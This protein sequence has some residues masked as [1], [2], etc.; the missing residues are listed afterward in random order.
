MRRGTR[1]LGRFDGIAALI[2]PTQPK[3]VGGDVDGDQAD[4]VEHT[5]WFAGATIAASLGA[6]GAARSAATRVPFA[7]AWG[8]DG[9]LLDCGE[10]C[11]LVARPLRGTIDLPADFPSGAWSVWFSVALPD[12][13]VIDAPAASL[14]IPERPAIRLVRTADPRVAALEVRA[15]Y[16][17]RISGSLPFRI[18]LEA[19]RKGRRGWGDPHLVC[20]PDAHG[21]RECGANGYDPRYYRAV[22]VRLT[23]PAAL[24]RVPVRVPAAGRWRVTVFLDAPTFLTLDE[25]P[26]RPLVFVAR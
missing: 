8:A 18:S 21:R 10:T 4:I 15:S 13:R 24:V 22:N 7:G 17:R 6:P 1:D 2:T 9:G 14:F 26:D 16:T 11:Y 20:G 12:G 19:M 5:D 23:R 25:E 3:F